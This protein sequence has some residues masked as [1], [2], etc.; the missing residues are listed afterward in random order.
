MR[1]SSMLK[2]INDHVEAGAC[3]S[4]QLD[5][6]FRHLWR[7]AGN[8]PMLELQYVYNG[9]PGNIYVKCE[10]YIS[11]YALFTSNHPICRLAYPVWFTPGQNGK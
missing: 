1:E 11:P 6:K 7:L 3:L 9:R 8:T 5:S 10:H 4:P 2:I